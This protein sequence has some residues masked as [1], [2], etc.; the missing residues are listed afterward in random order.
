VR[1][2][3]WSVEVTIGPGVVVRSGDTLVIGISRPLT[4]DQADQ[5]RDRCKE[6]LPADVGV[7]VVSDAAQLAVI[8]EQG[9]DT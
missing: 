5:I 3:R 7:I 6:Y 9:G 4:P 8:S 2:S 1:P